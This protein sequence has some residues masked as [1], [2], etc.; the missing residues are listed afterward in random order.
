MTSM[1]VMPYDEESDEDELSPGAFMWLEGDSLAPPCQSDRHVVSKIVEIARVTPDDV[2]SMNQ[3]PL[4]HSFT[5]SVLLVVVSCLVCFHR[6]YSTWDVEM[7][8]FA[9][10][11][12]DALVLVHEV[13]RL[14][15]F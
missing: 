10:K 14:K 8:G 5:R 2:R 3:A 4:V 9:L 7:D 12:Q 6:F 11:R 1:P 13:S 15:R